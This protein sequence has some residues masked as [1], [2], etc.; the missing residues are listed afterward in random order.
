MK[1]KRAPTKTLSNL[2]KINL[3]EIIILKVLTM[4]QSC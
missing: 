1:K 4:M 2:R 3:M